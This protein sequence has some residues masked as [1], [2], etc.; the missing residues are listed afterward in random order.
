MT[1]DLVPGASAE[2]ARQARSYVLPMPAAAEP[3]ESQL[4]VIS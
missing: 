2:A 1:L 3:N 4:P